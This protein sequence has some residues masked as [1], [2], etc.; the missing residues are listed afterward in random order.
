MQ[1]SARWHSDGDALTCL[2]DALLFAISGIR[3]MSCPNRQ[4]NTK[5]AADLPLYS[6]SGDLPCTTSLAPASEAV[7]GAPEVMIRGQRSLS[8]SSW[9]ATARLHAQTHTLAFTSL[10]VGVVAFAL[11]LVQSAWLVSPRLDWVRWW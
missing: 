8:N 6:Q 1:S 10:A 11:L 5:V 3:V 2:L 9:Q 4:G 7:P